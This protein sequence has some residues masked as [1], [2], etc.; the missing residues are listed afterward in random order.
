MK[1]IVKICLLSFILVG[2]KES[3]ANYIMKTFPFV[4]IV[5]GTFNLPNFEHYVNA[6]KT[7]RQL[8]LLSEG[9]IDEVQT[10]KRTSLPW[11]SLQSYHQLSLLDEKS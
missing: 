10:Y 2:Q 11:Q 8:E 1:K 7:G 6:V 9:D 4:D 5:I 3:T